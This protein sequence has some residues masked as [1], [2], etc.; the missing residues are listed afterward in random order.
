M[1]AV[2]RYQI[3]LL[4]RSYRWIPPF[5]LYGLAVVGLGGG[6]PPLADGLRWSALMLVPAVAW[7]TRAMLTAEP[8][9]A[10]ACVAAA[11]GPRLTQLAALAAALVTGAGYALV[12]VGYELITNARPVHAGGGLN[13]AAAFSALGGGLL[14]TLICLLVGSAVGTFCNPPLIRRPAAAMLSTTGSVVLALAWNVSPA[15]AAARTTSSPGHVSA[16]LPGLPVIAAVALLT[17]AWAVSALVAGH[18]AG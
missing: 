6:S 11:A 7:L 9:A 13:V 16:W 10:R 1:I 15:N 4:L 17:V 12:G 18:R 5:V 8:A 14:A 3:A 2:A